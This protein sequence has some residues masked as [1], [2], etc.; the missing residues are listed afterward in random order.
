MDTNS[1]SQDKVIDSAPHLI[2][3]NTG[4]PKMA[5]PEYGRNIHQMA[6]YCLTIDNPEERTRC[7]WSVI[8]VMATLFPHLVGETGDRRKLWDHLNIMTGFKLDIDFPVEVTG[9]ENLHPKPAPI[10]YTEAAPH[11]RQYGRNVGKIARIVAE[12]PEGEEKDAL[13][14]MLAHHMKKLLLVSNREAVSN[15]RVLHD[16][17][18]FTDGAVN[19]NPETYI[20]HD[21]LEPEPSIQGKGKKKKKKNM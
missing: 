20:L 4:M 16:L 15:E 17:S 7:A 2:P 1:T 5:V 12:L 6:Q 13:V 19:L 21:F 10:P 11:H 3:Y 8:D 18:N 14:S 9:P